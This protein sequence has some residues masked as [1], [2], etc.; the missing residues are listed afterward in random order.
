MAANLLSAGLDLSNASM[1]VLQARAGAW[2]VPAWSGMLPHVGMGRRLM[3]SAA[4][5]PP[6]PAVHLPMNSSPVLCASCIHATLSMPGS[7]LQFLSDHPQLL[8]REGAPEIRAKLRLFASWRLPP[9]MCPLLLARCPRLL[10]ESDE[11][12]QAGFGGLAESTISWPSAG[13]PSDAP[14][15]VP[16]TSG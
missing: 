8:T 4:P 3:L 15:H 2:H 10:R 12:L 13:L 5:F 7:L 1:E 16:A 6:L 11:Q 9:P 14:L